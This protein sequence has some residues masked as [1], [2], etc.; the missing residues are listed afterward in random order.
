MIN[1]RVTDDIAKG[2]HEKAIN[3]FILV[4]KCESEDVETIRG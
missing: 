1:L 4:N 2:E 3:T